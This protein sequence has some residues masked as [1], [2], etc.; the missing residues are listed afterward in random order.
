MVPKSDDS[1]LGSVPNSP[2]TKGFGSNE[3]KAGNCADCFPF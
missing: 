3:V 1:L 2:M